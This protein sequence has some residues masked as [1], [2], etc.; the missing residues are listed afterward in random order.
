M[1]LNNREIEVKT[2]GF[3]LL[4]WFFYLEK[5]GVKKQNS[6]NAE[7]WDI[8]KNIFFVTTL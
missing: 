8:L 2:I 3:C 7:N 1:D 5:L 4:L 6:K